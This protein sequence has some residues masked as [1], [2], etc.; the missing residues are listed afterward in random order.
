MM[1]E[2]QKITTFVIL[3]EKAAYWR[4]LKM[5]LLMLYALI[6]ESKVEGGTPSLAAA[7]DG[8]ETLPQ[9]NASASS[10]AFFS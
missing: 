5:C 3:R 9:V 4:N 10:M 2:N 6:F 7:P 1:P 8:P